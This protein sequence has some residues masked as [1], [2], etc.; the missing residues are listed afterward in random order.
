MSADGNEKVQRLAE[1][2][3]TAQRILVFTG[4]GI[5]TA[6]GIPDYRGPEGVWNTRRPVF[7]QDFMRSAEARRTYWQQKLEDHAEFGSASPNATHE[8]VATLEEAG[9]IEL[10][11]TQ[12]VDGLHAAAGTSLARLVEIHGTVRL[13]ECQSCGERTD[14]APHFATFVATGDAPACHCGGHLKSATISFGQSLRS[15]DLGRARAA[16]ENADLALALGS[17]LVVYPAADIPLHAAETGARYA[18]VNRGETDHDRNPLVTLRI[19]GDVTDV[20][21]AA[22]AKALA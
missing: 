9:K 10:V 13:V 1:L 19:D 8:A 17:S 12:N 7:Y 3:E 16:A 6:S 18:I 2:I 14:P 11:V 5:S 15:V 20:V 21:P 4:A 22:V